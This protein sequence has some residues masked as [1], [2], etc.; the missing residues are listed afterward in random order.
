MSESGPAWYGEQ[1]GYPAPAERVSFSFRSASPQSEAAL[2]Q[3]LLTRALG[4]SVLN[5]VQWSAIAIVALAVAC[6]L[7]DVKVLAVLIGLLAVF[8][9]L[10]RWMLA[11]LGRRLSG[12]DRLGAVEPQ[13]RRLVA[14]TGRQLRQ[15]LRRVGLPGT[16]WAPL[17]IALRLLRPYRRRQ[18]A[19][20]LARVDLTRVV[21]A[22]QLDEL[23][24]LLQ[25]A[26]RQN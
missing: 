22:S 9:L 23:H 13:V 20:A 26:G 12:A 21:P 16:P 5:T 1:P 3:Y 17:L 14:R 2:R 6:W 10:A 8:V 4:R 7:A 11:G 19:Q 15:E 18:T 24:L 25:S